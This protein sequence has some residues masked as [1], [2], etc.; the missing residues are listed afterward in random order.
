MTGVVAKMKTTAVWAALAAVL[1]AGAAS[2]TSAQERRVEFRFQGGLEVGVPIFLNVDSS[3]VRPGGSIMGWA[4]F[5]IGWF[6]L[7]FGLGFQWNAIQT[8]NI[9][10]VIGPA[11]LEPLTRLHFS[12]GVRLQVPTIDAVL[13]YITGAFD[14][15]IWSFPAFGRGCGWYYCR[16]DGRGKFAPGFTGKLGMGIHLKNQM[17][18]DVGV[19]FSLSGKG[20]F[21]D[22]TQYWLEPFIGFIYRSD[23]D[24]LSGTGL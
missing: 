16:D 8:N 12:P 5:D 10:E 1:M 15:N 3:I 14:A 13:P 23:Q 17:Y 9:P 6:V 2:T 7:D 11:G 19:Q 20:F 21:F 4:G 18:L 22:R 24:R